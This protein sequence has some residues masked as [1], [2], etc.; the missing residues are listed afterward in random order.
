MLWAI[1][2]EVVII[3]TYPLTDLKVMDVFKLDLSNMAKS[4]FLA[5]KHF[6]RRHGFQHQQASKL[7]SGN[8]YRPRFRLFLD[9]P[10]VGH[11]I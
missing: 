3:L 9:H 8:L 5:L 10:V 6:N 11:Q 1:L 7:T 4:L 2:I